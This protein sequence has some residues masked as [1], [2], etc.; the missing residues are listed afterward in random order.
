MAIPEEASTRSRVWCKTSFLQ[1][2]KSEACHARGFARCWI[3]VD[4][5]CAASPDAGTRNEVKEGCKWLACLKFNLLSHHQQVEPTHP[6]AI[7][8][9]DV[10]GAA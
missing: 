9:Q 5:E 10:Q 6:A 7:H 1:F 2:A 3:L 8:A 4:K